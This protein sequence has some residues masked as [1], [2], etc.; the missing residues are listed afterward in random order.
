M[1]KALGS[2]LIRHLFT[3][4][5][6]VRSVYWRLWRPQ[7]HR[8]A[9]GFGGC[10]FKAVSLS[11]LFFNECCCCCDVR[12]PTGRATTTLIMVTAV[13]WVTEAPLA[14]S[15]VSRDALRFW[16]CLKNTAV[17][18]AG[19]WRRAA[20]PAEPLCLRRHVER[21]VLFL[22]ACSSSLFSCEESFTTPR[23]HKQIQAQRGLGRKKENSQISK[24]HGGWVVL[25]FREAAAGERARTLVKQ[26]KE[27]S[28]KPDRLQLSF[29][30]FTVE[31]PQE[32]RTAGEIVTVLLCFQPAGTFKSSAAVLFS[33]SS[34]RSRFLLRRHDTNNFRWWEEENVFRWAS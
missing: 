20:A 14:L 11:S 34:Q 23:L 17:S 26:Q 21:F 18:Q 13:F 7:M 24:K 28:F 5:N 1:L 9:G 2:G 27:E 12:W 33:D 8:A 15:A 16:W 25:R 6:L 19:R 30:N 32:K 22:L 4:F 10:G 31:T 3:F 29:I